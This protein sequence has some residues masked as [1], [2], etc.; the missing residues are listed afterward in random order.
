MNLSNDELLRRY[1]TEL[2]L[3]VRNQRNLKSDRALLARFIEHVGGVP[4]TGDLAKAFL[5][6]HTDRELSTQ[7]RYASTLRAFMKWYGDPIEDVRIKA[8]RPLPQ[9]V[10]AGDIDTLI[11][12]LGDK[13]SHRNTIVRDQLMV[14]LYYRTGMRQSELADLEVGNVHGD[15]LVVR[16]GRGGKDRMI[17]LLED[18]A[19]RLS[20]FCRGRDPSEKVFGLTG[21]SIGNKIRRF[22]DRVGLKGVHTHS[23]RHKYATDLLESGANIRVVQQLLGHADLSTTQVYLSLTDKSLREAV[24]GL[25][26]G[27]TGVKRGRR[28]TR[29]ATE[30]AVDVTLRPEE[31]DPLESKT[32]AECGA[33]FSLALEGDSV[34]IESM[35]LRTDDPEVPYR[36]M[37]FERDPE[38]P[39]LD[40]EKEDMV[41]MDLTRQRVF[42]YPSGSPVPYANASGQRVLHGAVVIGQRPLPVALLSREHR[43]QLMAHLQQP[44][45][46]RVT[47]RYSVAPAHRRTSD[48]GDARL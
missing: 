22:A 14:E 4:L 44:V 23:L 8:P 40:L 35:Q 21:P 24:D 1:D 32:I 30:A 29:E 31:W 34:L 43:E 17:P 37:V 38:E 11:G 19:D 16:K 41:Q 9:Y 18:I 3:R 46:F 15:F 28:Q 39:S 48:G 10:E 13:R 7:A 27:A 6:E 42:S 20:E 26:E 36:L 25:A 5:A 33:L 45:H 47:L 12:A 2:M